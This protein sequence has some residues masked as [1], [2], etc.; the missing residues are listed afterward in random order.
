[1]KASLAAV[2]EMSAD[3][4]HPQVTCTKLGC[5]V[6]GLKSTLSEYPSLLF[7]LEWRDEILIFCPLM[8]NRA[9]LLTTFV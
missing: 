1:M 3:V 5:G 7:W 6:S 9:G 8:T 4:V 2:F